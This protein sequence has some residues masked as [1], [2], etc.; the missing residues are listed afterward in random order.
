[1]SP[2]RHV[3]SWLL[4]AALVTAGLFLRVFRLA[5]IP[6]ALF[7]DEAEKACNAFAI[8]RTGHD[9]SG[10]FLP[11]FINVFGVT[12][13]AI[14]QYVC[15]PFVALLGLNEWSARLPAVL[16]ALATMLLTYPLI[17]RERGR[18]AA[19]WGL[20]FL[21]FS[22]WHITF[23]RWAQ[24]GIFL[25]FLLAGGMYAL[26]LFLDGKR[27][28]LPVCAALL[29]LAIYAYDPARLFVP[30]LGLFVLGIYWRELLASWKWAIVAL[31]AFALFVS[32]V[33]Y[34]L[35]TQTSA[36]QARFNAITILQPGES[37]AEVVR[38]FAS[39]YALHFSPGFLVLHGDSELRHGPGVGV[40]GAFE[41]IALICGVIVLLRRHRKA[42]FV[43]LTWILFF[44]VAASLTRIGIPHALRTIVA[45][46]ALQIV[47]GIG[48][49]EI[50]ANLRV[51]R[52]QPFR[53]AAALALLLSFLPFAYRYFGDYRVQSATNWQY[54]IKQAIDTLGTSPPKVVFLNIFGGEYLAGFYGRLSPEEFRNGISGNGRFLFPPFGFP[55]ERLQSQLPAGSAIVTVPLGPI[56]R[57]K[58]L[59]IRVPGS[60]ET[61]AEIVWPE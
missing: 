3:P 17:R 43:W 16:V 15:V 13:S 9:V 29:A 25:P 18:E 1:M 33:A 57:A 59:P 46:P 36:A 38:R 30:L 55:L 5:D 8:L 27:W 49:A 40:L 14:Y 39:N 58:V 34:L 2:R 6:P 48:V 20:A 24:Q 7:R 52:I 41:F 28:M 4:P 47:A 50:A 44:P 12:T 53:R 51:S 35:L 45:I 60:D 31:L 42:D 22:P 10:N 26:R 21:A 54:G 61:V 56:P 19:L 32:P 11:I 37:V 23:S